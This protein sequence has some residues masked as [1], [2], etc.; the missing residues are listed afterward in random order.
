M[1]PRNEQLVQVILEGKAE[2]QRKALINQLDEHE[3]LREFANR[4]LM[5]LHWAAERIEEL[6]STCDDLAHDR[7]EWRQRAQDRCEEAEKWFRKYGEEQE[8]ADALAN[9]GQ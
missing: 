3:D 1:R 2:A 5:R 9:E 6:E 7:N 4:M 8:R